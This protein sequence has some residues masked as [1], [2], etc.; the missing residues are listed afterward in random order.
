MTC[1]FADNAFSK[2]QYQGI[3]HTLELI[4]N[5]SSV[6]TYHFRSSEDMHTFQALITGFTVVF[7]GYVSTFAISRRRMV[8][9]IYKR[10]E[11]SATRLQIIRQGTIFQ[12]IAFFKDFSHGCCMNFI[13]KSTDVFESFSR[14]NR[15]FI[16]IV[17][18]KFA[19]PRNEA[20]PSNGFVSID[21]PEY[22]SEHDDI[23]IGFET[24]TGTL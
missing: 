14:S 24:T 16:R 8:V 7:D 12:L 23:T 13:L 10:L 2:E 18:A 9:P 3:Q 1:S 11:A 22:P 5:V 6:R 21:M 17:D 4:G 19:L 15:S 20:D